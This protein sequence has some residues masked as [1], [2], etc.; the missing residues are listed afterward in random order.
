MVYYPDMSG[1]RK[2]LRQAER[3]ELAADNPRYRDI[4]GR[5]TPGVSQYPS[6]TWE[7]HFRRTAQQIREGVDDLKELRGRKK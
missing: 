4:L 5:R 6:D 3:Y 1:Y 7:G 2:K